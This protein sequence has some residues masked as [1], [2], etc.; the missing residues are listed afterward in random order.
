MILRIAALL[1]AR[2]A[3]PVR[4]AAMEVV[5]QANARR[6]VA[7]IPEVRVPVIPRVVAVSATTNSAPVLERVV[8]AGGIMCAA[9]LRVTEASVLAQPMA[10]PV[11]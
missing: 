8:L 11:A 1:Q 2:H 4:I 5:S 6:P 3:L 10:P 9:A 7:Q